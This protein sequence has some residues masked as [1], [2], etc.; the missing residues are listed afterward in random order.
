MIKSYSKNEGLGIEAAKAVSEAAK[1]TT[2]KG[3]APFSKAKTPTSKYK[4]SELDEMTP[5]QR[6]ALE[7]RGPI[8]MVR[9]ADGKLVMEYAP[10]EETLDARKSPYRNV[11]GKSGAPMF[12]I[13]KDLYKSVNDLIPKRIKTKEDYID[14]VRSESLENLKLANAIIEEGGVINNYIRSK[15]EN[16]QEGD[17]IIGNLFFRYQGLTEKGDLSKSGFAYDPQAKRKT[18]SKEPVSFVEYI[19]ANTR[20]SKM[21][22]K[23]QLFEESKQIATEDISTAKKLVGTEAADKRV[24]EGDTKE[25]PNKLQIKVQ[26]FAGVPKDLSIKSSIKPSLN[27]GQIS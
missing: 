18:G 4:K 14:F 19:L 12:S 22:A 6:L 2:Q 11:G 3:E 23:K 17:K 26:D 8:R 1:G 20:F 5:N 21:V 24:L 7:G 25:K 15:Q 9:N 16:Q 27:F 10:I 13:E